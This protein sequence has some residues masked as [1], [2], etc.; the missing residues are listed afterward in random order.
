MPSCAFKTRSKLG[1]V[2]PSWNTTHPV[3]DGVLVLESP[4]W[5]FLLT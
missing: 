5:D 2:F 3:G 4:C 1:R